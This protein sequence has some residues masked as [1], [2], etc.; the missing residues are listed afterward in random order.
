MNRPSFSRVSFSIT[1]AVTFQAR[2]I[3]HMKRA[4]LTFSG[5]PG[6]RQLGSCARAISRSRSEQWW[7]RRSQRRGKAESCPPTIQRGPR[8]LASSAHNRVAASETCPTDI[9]VIFEC[10]DEIGTSPRQRSELAGLG[11]SEHGDPAI[12]SHVPVS[13]PN[14]PSRVTAL[15]HQVLRV[16]LSASSRLCLARLSNRYERDQSGVMYRRLAKGS[17]AIRVMQYSLGSPRL[18]CFCHAMG[19][20]YRNWRMQ[21]TI[22]PI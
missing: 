18:F 2:Y 7:M 13:T 20:A 15:R 14:C 8:K 6:C 16:M 9:K 10:P 1:G 17:I 19:Y 11:R 12:R 4:R 22:E 21:S 3:S 5:T